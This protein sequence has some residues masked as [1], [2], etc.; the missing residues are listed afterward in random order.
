MDGMCMSHFVTEDLRRSFEG[1]LGKNGHTFVPLSEW[2]KEAAGYLAQA[3]H[4]CDFETPC[5]F[6]EFKDKPSC[7][8]YREGILHN[9]V[10][11]FFEEELEERKLALCYYDKEKSKLHFFKTLQRASHST[12]EVWV[13]DYEA[14]KAEASIA[15][16]LSDRVGERVIDEP[17]LANVLKWSQLGEKFKLSNDQLEI[18]RKALEQNM[19]VVDGGPGTGKTTI[20]R[21]IYQYYFDMFPDKVFCCAPTGK[22]AKRMSEA[23]HSDACT[24]HRLLGAVYDEDTEETV[25]TYTSKNHHPGKVYLV[26]EASMID[27]VVF[28]AFLSAIDEQATLIL[29]GDSHQLPSVGAGRVL[30]DLIGSDTVPVC[31]LVENFRQLHDS[32]IVQ[33]ASLILHGKSMVFPKEGEAESDCHLIPCRPDEMLEKVT[34][35][36]NRMDPDMKPERWKDIA[37]LCPKRKGAI[38]TNAI[39]ESLQKTRASK[40][41]TILHKLEVSEC[42]YRFFAKDDRVIQSKNNY[43]LACKEADGEEGTGVFNGDIGYVDRVYSS[44]QFPLDIVFDDSRRASYAMKNLAELEIAYALTVHKAQGGEWKHV[45]LVLPPEYGPIFNRNLLYTAVTRAKE[46]LW[47]LGD[48]QTI[49][50]MIRSQYSET[51][52]TALQIFLRNKKEKT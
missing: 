50:R 1:I 43:N 39:N 40:K 19:V 24:M 45:L 13:A 47:I 6:C 38:S 23:T 33:N 37:I 41:G 36:A 3:W 25:F 52:R 49:D 30:A 29:V 10:G 17:R 9:F 27:A 32:M 22:A 18:V 35:W 11:T 20:L 8:T 5:T 16:R 14:I 15:H 51:R 31:T 4:R 34:A 12:E 42:N 48:V 2:K 21:I 7:Q 26:D 28:D 44:S 46:E